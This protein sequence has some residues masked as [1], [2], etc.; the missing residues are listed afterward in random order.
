MSANQ[1]ETQTD[2]WEAQGEI[3][4]SPRNNKGAGW[5]SGR[6]GTVSNTIYKVKPATYITR[7]DENVM[8]LWMSK[9]CTKLQKNHI[10][11]HFHFR[12]GAAHMSPPVK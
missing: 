8:S 1:T 11:A 9:V 10:T 5:H 4:L 2:I 12:D 3:N 7:P 6:Y